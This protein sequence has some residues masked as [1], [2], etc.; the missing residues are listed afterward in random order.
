MPDKEEAQKNTLENH[1]QRI[2]TETTKVESG[3]FVHGPERMNEIDH[4]EEKKIIGEI[5]GK[6]A[7]AGNIVAATN[8]REETR[9]EEKEIEK[10]LES[11]L[12]DIYLKM[13]PEKQKEFKAKGEETAKKINRLLHKAKVKIKDII[14]LIKKWLAVIPGVNKFFI[15]KEAKIKTDE[16]V[17]I[18]NKPF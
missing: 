12:E 9:R 13:S 5:S 14:D 10:A 4:E 8:A 16:I 3:P 2:K 18:K 6:D 17:K 1:E 15:E 11:G 7:D